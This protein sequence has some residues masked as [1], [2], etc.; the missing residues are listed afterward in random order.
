MAP[1]W[2]HYGTIKVPDKYFY[3]C[4]VVLDGNIYLLGIESKNKP[5]GII[6]KINLLTLKIT[7]FMPIEDL[8]G[9]EYGEYSNMCVYGPHILLLVHHDDKNPFKLLIINTINKKVDNL[10]LNFDIHRENLT[11]LYV[12]KDHLYIIF[13]QWFKCKLSVLDINLKTFKKKGPFYGALN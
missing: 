7:E 1:M 13:R 12:I 4:A 3:K 6:S 2:Y 8:E 10:L 5:K 11:D 9:I